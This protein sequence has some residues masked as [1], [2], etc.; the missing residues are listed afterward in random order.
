MHLDR[1]E[2]PKNNI[3]ERWTRLA[4]STQH[5]ESAGCPWQAVLAQSNETKKRLLVIRALELS[6]TKHQLEDS[7]L[8]EALRTLD[9]IIG[10]RDTQ[11]NEEGGDPNSETNNFLADSEQ[12]TLSCP[13][14]PKRS[15]R[16]RDTSQK[17]WT[18]H[19]KLEKETR[20]PTIVE[21]EENREGTSNKTAMKT[22]RVSD[23]LQVTNK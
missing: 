10:T 23:L 22:R 11:E 2:I 3:C 12:L 18:K 9:N 20:R 15:G 16:P 5:E 14:R 6:Q 17:S 4:V 7:K 8:N 13:P 19:N 21:N 1:T